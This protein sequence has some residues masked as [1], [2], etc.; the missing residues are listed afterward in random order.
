MKKLAYF[1]FLLL[2]LTR[3]DT[4]DLNE[5]E[6]LSPAPDDSYSSLEIEI[7]QEINLYR[8]NK[9]LPS[10]EMNEIIYEEAL[11]HT[12]YMIAQ[13]AINHDNFSDRANRLMNNPGGSSAAENV[14]FGYTSAKA[15][16]SGWITSDGHRK[17]IEGNYNLTGIAAVNDKNGRYY[18]TQIFLYKP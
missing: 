6:I 17:N 10:F 15:V 2:V 16:V 13:G 1:L 4:I 8:D 5:E 11:K 9:G 7:L 14:A 18:F 3:C 12:E